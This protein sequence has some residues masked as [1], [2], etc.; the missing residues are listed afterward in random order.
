M[1]SAGDGLRTLRLTHLYDN[2]C[3][4]WTKRASCIKLTL[5][6]MREEYRALGFY[7]LKRT[8][9]V[10]LPTMADTGCQNCLISIGVTQQI[11]MDTNDFIPVSMTMK[12][13][14][15]KGN[16]ILGAVVIR[17]TGNSRTRRL[18]THQFEYV[19]ITSNR[20]FLS[21]EIMPKYTWTWA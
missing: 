8:R 3:D 12:A 2:T 1:D 4:K 20:I 18:E 9:D 16:R 11:G 15:N 6:N 17:F 14:N 13:A 21:R 10:Y 7:L 5:T 19:A